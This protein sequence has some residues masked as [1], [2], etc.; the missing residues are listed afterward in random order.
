MR[1]AR[2]GLVAAVSATIAC[3]THTVNDLVPVPLAPPQ[4]SVEALIADLGSQ[5]PATRAAAAWDAAGAGAVSDAWQRPSSSSATI[6]IPMPSA[7]RNGHSDTCPTLWS[8]T[9]SLTGR[10]PLCDC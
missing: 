3:A 8:R 2:A 5:D 6:P 1:V 10:A 9:A 7:R 4:R